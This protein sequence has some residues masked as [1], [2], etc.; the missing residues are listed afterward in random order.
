MSDSNC[1]GPDLARLR[2]EY[3]QS[4]LSEGDIDPSPFRQ[5]ILWLNQ[6][7]A[8][9]VHEPNAMCL[10]TATPDGIPSSRMVLLKQI[11]E[12]GL[13]FYTNYLSRKARELDANPRAA[14]VFY[15]PELERQMRAEGDVVRTSDEESGR[16][17]H[18]RPIDAQLASAASPQSEPIASREYIEQRMR[19]LRARYPTAPIPRPDHWGGYR[20]APSR[21]EFWQGRESRL[22]DRLEY[23]CDAGRWVIRRL[24]P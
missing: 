15:W 16:Y 19:E 13:A 14:V 20:L 17:F 1:A 12:R 7:I 3:R 22:H 6:A 5:S 2:V 9:R 8:A 23:R 10:A 11:D 18:S 21:F 4:S 24:A